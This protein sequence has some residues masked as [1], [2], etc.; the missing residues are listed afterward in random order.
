MGHQRHLSV[1][2]DA[3]DGGGER[4]AGTWHALG[5]GHRC[6]HVAR[7]GGKGEGKGSRRG[8]GRRECGR[9]DCEKRG[10]EEGARGTGTAE[11][12]HSLVRVEC[13]GVGGNTRRQG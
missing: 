3:G 9:E 4:P 11:G 6:G 5:P 2:M 12:R 8:G 7:L 10:G 13:R 1:L